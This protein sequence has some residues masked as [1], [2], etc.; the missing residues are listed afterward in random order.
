MVPDRVDGEK[1]DETQV[2]IEAEKLVLELDENGDGMVTFNE[3]ESYFEKKA[4]EV[5]DAIAAI[6]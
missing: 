2:A 4:Q 6:T 5:V 3:F 1:M